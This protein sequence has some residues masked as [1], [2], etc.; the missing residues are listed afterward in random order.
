MIF[1][2]NN[3]VFHI[4]NLFL[5]IRINNLYINFL[6]INFNLVAHD[7]KHKKL[8]KE[9]ERWY[10]DAPAGAPPPV[11]PVVADTKDS[12]NTETSFTTLDTILQAVRAIEAKFDER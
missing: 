4:K 7:G 3:F 6:G 2:K 11:A 8:S 1:Y 12:D 10:D 9:G 5:L